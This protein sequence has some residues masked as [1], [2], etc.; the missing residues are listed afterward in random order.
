MRHYVHERWVGRDNHKEATSGLPACCTSGVTRSMTTGLSGRSGLSFLSEC[1]VLS[2]IVLKSSRRF[3][4]RDTSSSTCFALSL[5]FF[6]FFFL[7]ESI[8]SSKKN[9]E[10]TSYTKVTHREAMRLR[11]LGS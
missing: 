6:F 3:F 5:F 7:I 2:D 11:Y 1:F 8:Y 9:T 4:R 10:Y